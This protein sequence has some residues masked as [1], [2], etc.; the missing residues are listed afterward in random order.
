M[1]TLVDWR[2]PVFVTMYIEARSTALLLT[3]LIFSRNTYQRAH[4][5]ARILPLILLLLCPPFQIVAPALSPVFRHGEQGYKCTM[6]C[7][8]HVAPVDD[9]LAAAKLILK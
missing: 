5:A 4:G 1:V 8:G 2:I 3:Y 6:I 9:C 7:E